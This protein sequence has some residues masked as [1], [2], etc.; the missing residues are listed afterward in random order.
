MSYI[1]YKLIVPFQFH[2][3]SSIHV[4]SQKKIELSFSFKQT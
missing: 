3:K 1:E 4:I 2:M